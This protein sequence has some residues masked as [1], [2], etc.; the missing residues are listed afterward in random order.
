MPVLKIASTEFTSSD[1]VV[2]SIFLASECGLTLSNACCLPNGLTMSLFMCAEAHRSVQVA[3]SEL[4]P[5]YHFTLPL[6]ADLSNG[7][8]S[9]SIAILPRKFL[10]YIGAY[11]RVTTTEVSERISLLIVAIHFMERSLE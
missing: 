8:L 2:R 11:L 3:Q 10:K 1:L 4:L 5:S 7:F 9:R 6:R